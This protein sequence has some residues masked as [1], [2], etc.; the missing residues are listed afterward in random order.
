M[1]SSLKSINAN[2]PASNLKNGK[3][4]SDLVRA[5]IMRLYL[6]IRLD[7]QT[8]TS[9]WLGYLCQAL[10]VRVPT[11]PVTPITATRTSGTHTG[12]HVVGGSATASLRSHASLERR[13][14]R[15]QPISFASIAR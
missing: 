10:P 11:T 14:R 5:D 6:Q 15:H 8:L 12:P 2:C 1:R 3:R 13:D 7:A 9:G 4:L